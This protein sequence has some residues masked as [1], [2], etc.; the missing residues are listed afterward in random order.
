MLVHVKTTNTSLPRV[1]GKQLLINGTCEE[2]FIF[3]NGLKIIWAF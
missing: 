2:S 3:V 1:Y